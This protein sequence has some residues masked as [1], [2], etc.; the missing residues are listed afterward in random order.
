MKVEGLLQE[1]SN[2]VMEFVILKEVNIG[3]SYLLCWVL[4]NSILELISWVFE[5]NIK[6]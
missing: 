1:S 4:G 3:Y 5:N 2:V 6:K